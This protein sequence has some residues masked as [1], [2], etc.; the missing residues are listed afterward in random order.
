MQVRILGPFQPEE[1]GRRIP[2]GGARQRTALAGLLLQAN[3]VRPGKQLL[4]ICGVRT[5]RRARRTL[6]RPRSHDCDVRFRQAASSQGG[7]VIRCGSFQKSWQTA[8]RPPQLA[9]SRRS[10]LFRPPSCRVPRHTGPA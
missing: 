1:G 6:F 10:A 4:M 3:E 7:R 9:G 2:I 8:V 5:P